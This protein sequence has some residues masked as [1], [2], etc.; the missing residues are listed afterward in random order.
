MVMVASAERVTNCHVVRFTR[1][2]LFLH[3]LSGTLP[4]RFLPSLNG[5]GRHGVCSWTFDFFALTGALW[6]CANDPVRE[7]DPNIQAAIQPLCKLGCGDTDPNPNAPGV[8][9]GS[10]VTADLC[11]DG[12]QTDTDQDLLSDFCEFN[13]G[14][15]FAPEL[16]YASND[17]IGRESHWVAMPVSGYP[18]VRIAY[19]LSYYQ[20]NGTSSPLCNNS[21]GDGPC[22]GHYGDS[23]WI[24]LDVRYNGTTHH[25]VLI[26][27]YYSQHESMATY[28]QGTDDYPMQ[29]TYPS[30]PGAYP[31]S[32]VAFGKHANYG[33]QSECD[34]GGALG[35]DSC[36]LANSAVQVSAG[37]NLN[38]GSRSV[39]TTGQDCMISSNPILAP[40]GYIECYWTN[41]RFGGWS[42]SLPNSSAYS[43][44]LSTLGF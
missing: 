12:E 32:W 15:A 39:H 34:S 13:L 24:A 16:W 9:L 21:F 23:E 8:Y 43:P 11:I 1:S 6:S 22:A 4:R 33:S 2:S 5:S 36:S 30:H 26:D 19:L 31:R 38:L 29:L 25:W 17:D 3:S 37:G 35:Y 27:A 40:Y 28:A 10:G 18:V 7:A 14:A 41:R 20:D 42:G 44:K